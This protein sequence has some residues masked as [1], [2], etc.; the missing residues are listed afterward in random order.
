MSSMY[1]LTDM[2]GRGASESRMVVIGTFEFN[3]RVWVVLAVGFVP[4]M[5]LTLFTYLIFGVWAVLAFPL[6]EGGALLLF[7]YRPETGMRLRLWQSI[8]DRKQATGRFGTQPKV[9]D[10]ALCGRVVDPEFSAW[11]LVEIGTVPVGTLPAET[12]QQEPAHGASL[13]SH[14]SAAGG[15]PAPSRA[16]TPWWGQTA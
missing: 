16:E 11:A 4:A 15:A 6:A 10:F 13:T 7:V 3:W 9:G 1:S 8:R 14:T 2:T 5:F 12:G